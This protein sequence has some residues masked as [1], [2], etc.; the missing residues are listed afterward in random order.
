MRAVKMKYKIEIIEDGEGRV[1]VYQ[2]SA[3]ELFFSM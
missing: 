2:A 3:P 1:R